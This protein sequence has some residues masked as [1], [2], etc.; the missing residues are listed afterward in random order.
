LG[1]ADNTM[2]GSDAQP[3]TD[4]TIGPSQSPLSLTIAVAKIIDNAKKLRCLFGQRG[5]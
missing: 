3:L 2:T 1:G 5:H 4:H